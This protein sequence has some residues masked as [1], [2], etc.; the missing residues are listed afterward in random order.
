[1]HNKL[2]I[3]PPKCTQINTSATKETEIKSC[4]VYILIY[5]RKELQDL[6]KQMTFNQF[7]SL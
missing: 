4:I 1:M 5:S 3:V 6:Q 2:Q 7:M